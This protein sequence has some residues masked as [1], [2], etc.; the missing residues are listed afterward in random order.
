MPFWAWTIVP[1][2]S[3]DLLYGF[4]LLLPNTRHELKQHA[5][6]LL[7]AQVIAVSCFLIWPLRFT[8]ERPELDGV[9]GWLFAVLAGFDKPF[10]QAPSLH[11]ALLVI[12]WVMYQRHTQGFWRWVVH[13]WFTLIGVSVL[14]TYQHHF[15]DLPTGALAGWLCVWLW[16]VAH[17]SPLLRRAIDARF[18]ALA[19]GDALWVRCLGPDGAGLGARW[20]VAMA[21]MASGFLG[22][23]YGQL[24]CTRCAGLSKTRRW[25]PD[26]CRPLVV[27]ALS[28]GRL[29][30]FA[31]VDTQ[32]ST[33]GPDCG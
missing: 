25:P 13:G 1:Y 10:N 19:A 21:A 9:F 14:T 16:P 28:G 15:I 22:V 27:C 11:I 3:I 24:P 12:L 7:S 33:A 8:F 4:S 2:W 20:R 23:D 32:T 29:D 5:L 18:P 17:P 6:R 30:Q 31:A 26:A